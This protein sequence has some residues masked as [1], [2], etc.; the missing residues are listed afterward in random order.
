MAGIT[1][2]GRFY[3]H[4]LTLIAAWISMDFITRRQMYRCTSLQDRSC[5]YKIKIVFDQVYRVLGSIT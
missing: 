3:K 4:G 2:G 5:K 1:A